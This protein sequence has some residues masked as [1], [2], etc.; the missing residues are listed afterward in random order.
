MKDWVHC[1]SSGLGWVGSGAFDVHVVVRVTCSA[2]VTTNEL[3]YVNYVASVVSYLATATGE[4]RQSG[5]FSIFSSLLG[6]DSRHERPK[7]SPFWS[8]MPG[9]GLGRPKWGTGRRLCSSFL[10]LFY[11]PRI[12]EY[13]NSN[14]RIKHALGSCVPGIAHYLA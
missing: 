4:V 7:S 14:S 9:A 5:P 2:F 11:V 8:F 12:A 6:F 10:D 1:T 13:R 3:I